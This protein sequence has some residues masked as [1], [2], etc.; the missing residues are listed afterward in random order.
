MPILFG[1]F[2]LP[3]HAQISKDFHT[4]GRQLDSTGPALLNVDPPVLLSSL[5]DKPSWKRI[6]E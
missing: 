5:E 6:P 3:K 2:D 1:K 4:L